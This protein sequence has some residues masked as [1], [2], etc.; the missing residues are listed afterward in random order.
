MPSG[1]TRD[2]LYTREEKIVDVAIEVPKMDC[3]VFYN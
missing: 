1:V 3:S 2:N